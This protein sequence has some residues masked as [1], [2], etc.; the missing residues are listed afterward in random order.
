MSHNPRLPLKFLNAE[1]H[2]SNCVKMH[3]KIRIYEG[4]IKKDKKFSGDGDESNF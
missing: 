2:I 1:L 4:R 3:G